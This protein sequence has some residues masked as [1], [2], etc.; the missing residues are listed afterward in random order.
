MYPYHIPQSNSSEASAQSSSKSHTFEKGMHKSHRVG[1]FT[2]SGL[3][4]N[5][6]YDWPTYKGRER[7]KC[8]KQIWQ[9]VAYFPFKE[10]QSI[11][12]FTGHILSFLPN[13]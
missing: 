13:L 4:K 8:C 6:M 3:P 1:L 12:F 7:E 11:L 2:K 5:K 9:A 10:A